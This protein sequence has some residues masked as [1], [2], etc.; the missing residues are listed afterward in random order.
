MELQLIRTCYPKGTNGILLFN[1]TELCKTVE[2]PWKN[3]QPRVS[4]IPQGNYR[5]RKRCSPKFKSHFEVMEV[6]DRKYILFHAANDAGKELRGCIAPVT[7]HTGE[8]KGSASRAALQRMKDRLYP[9]MD[10][11]HKITLTIK[12]AEK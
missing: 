6:K 10:N 3:N 4:C 7:E 9:L 1:G 8:G 5:L 11:G 12:N 2:L